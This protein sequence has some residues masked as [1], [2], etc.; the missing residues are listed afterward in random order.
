MREKGRQKERK[1][2][3]IIRK[4]VRKKEKKVNNVEEKQRGGVRERSAGTVVGN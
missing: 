1:M 3:R 4:E 2:L